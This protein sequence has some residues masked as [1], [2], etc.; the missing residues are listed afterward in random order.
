MA[1]ELKGKKVAFI[2]TDKFEQVELTDPW[3]ALQGA[4]ADV[5]LIAPHD[6]HI[7]G[8]HHGER[9]DKFP[10]D[11]TF[12]QTSPEDYDAL[13]IPGGVKNPDTLRQDDRAVKF[14]RAFIEAGKPVGAICHGPWMLVEADAIRG[15]TLT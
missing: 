11:L 15:R 4:G 14:V 3:D 1:N 5:E 6:G 13:V 7:E 8:V 10:V 9:G 12:E 2:A